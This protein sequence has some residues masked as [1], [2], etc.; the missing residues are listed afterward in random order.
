MQNPFGSDTII[1]LLGMFFP[2]HRRASAIHH[3]KCAHSACILNARK[4]TRV[5]AYHIAVPARTQ[6]ED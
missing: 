5:F 4:P 3:G 6:K 1:S 2:A